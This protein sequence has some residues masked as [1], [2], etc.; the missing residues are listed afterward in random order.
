MF[1]ALMMSACTPVQVLPVHP[2]GRKANVESFLSMAGLTTQL[3]LPFPIAAIGASG[4]NVMSFCVLATW[5]AV[6]NVTSTGTVC[7]A[8]PLASPTTMLAWPGTVTVIMPLVQSM[9]SL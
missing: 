3:G 2:P 8:A 5:S 7:P 4:G 1:E 6:C 9:P